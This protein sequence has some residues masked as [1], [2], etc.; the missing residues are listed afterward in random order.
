MRKGCCFSTGSCKRHLQAALLGFDRG[1]EN[2]DRALDH[3][4]L[5]AEWL[6]FTLFGIILPTIK[7]KVSTFGGL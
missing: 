7:L 6:H 5:A 1:P 2:E 3:I 4:I